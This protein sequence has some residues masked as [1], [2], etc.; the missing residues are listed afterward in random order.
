M[1]TQLCKDHGFSFFLYMWQAIPI[2]RQPHILEL[3][4]G[5][6]QDKSSIVRKSALQLLKTCLI[7]NPFGAQ[8]SEYPLVQKVKNITDETVFLFFFGVCV[9]TKGCHRESS[10]YFLLFYPVI[11]LYIYL[12]YLSGT[13]WAGNGSFSCLYYKVQTAWVCGVLSSSIQFPR[14]IIKILLT[15]FSWSIL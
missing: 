2:S 9:Y 14:D 7:Y 8:V 10:S 6:L 4:I 15:S 12:L 5:R 1:V 11:Y 13:M 3:A